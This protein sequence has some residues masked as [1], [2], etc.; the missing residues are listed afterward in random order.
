VL[1]P[2]GG[3]R[4]HVW[5]TV[6]GTSH[7]LDLPE[8]PEAG[9]A[10]ADSPRLLV[11]SDLLVWSTRVPDTDARQVRV[12]ASRG[13]VAELD[14]SSWQV[15]PAAALPTGAPVVVA[16]GESLVVVG[17]AAAWIGTPSGE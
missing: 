5:D 12:L 3:H 2:A 16:L 4:L 6:T 10:R 17:P 14:R 8:P 13:W 15:G 9:S 1:T 7:E 11:P